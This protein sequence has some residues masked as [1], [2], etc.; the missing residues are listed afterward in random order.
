MESFMRNHIY[1][2]FGILDIVITVIKQF[3]NEL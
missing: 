1:K 3:G 2:N